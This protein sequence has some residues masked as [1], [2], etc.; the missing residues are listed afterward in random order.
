MSI[1]GALL[2]LL[3]CIAMVALGVA[4][5]GGAILMIFATLVTSLF[6]F[7]AFLYSKIRGG[8]SNG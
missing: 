8:G 6:S 1:G 5:I 4:F 3:A 2:I 7:F